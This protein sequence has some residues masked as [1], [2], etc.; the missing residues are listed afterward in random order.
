MELQLQQLPAH[1][2]DVIDVDAE[3]NILDTFLHGI[4]QDFVGIN[5]GCRRQLAGFI[6]TRYGIATSVADKALRK[7]IHGA[8][9]DWE[10]LRIHDKKVCLIDHAYEISSNRSHGRRVSGCIVSTSRWAGF[11]IHQET[12]GNQWCAYELE[13]RQCIAGRCGNT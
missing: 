9:A 13:A 4:G 3:R 5:Y 1:R 12:P 2:Y 10:G 8:D 7:L 11:I 6:C